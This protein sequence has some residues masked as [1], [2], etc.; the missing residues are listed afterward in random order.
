MSA[1]LTVYIPDD[2]HVDL[3]PL[4]NKINVSSIC[5]RALVREVE[6]FKSISND[7]A[8]LQNLVATLRKGK[9]AHWDK[10][11]KQGFQQAVEDWVSWETEIENPEGAVDTFEELKWIVDQG[12]APEDIIDQFIE[13][14]RDDNKDGARIYF[15]VDAFA[16]GYVQGVR[17]VYK[18]VKKYLK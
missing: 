9:A 15:N 12:Q 6:Y 13:N 8:V 18:N 14:C 1:R 2:L 17:S 7:D 5:Q 16:E 4:R 3:E 11:K 10:W